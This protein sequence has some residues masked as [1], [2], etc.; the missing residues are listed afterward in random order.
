MPITV[1][2]GP[3]KSGRTTCAKVKVAD[4]VADIGFTDD[5]VLWLKPDTD[6][7]R[8]AHPKVV[9]INNIELFSRD[10]LDSV[11][12]LFETA[13]HVIVTCLNRDEDLE[14]VKTCVGKPDDVIHLRPPQLK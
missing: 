13:A 7:L 2:S 6:A 1:F 5:Q 10:L 3:R 14:M 11:R 9:V 8:G 12:P 4:L